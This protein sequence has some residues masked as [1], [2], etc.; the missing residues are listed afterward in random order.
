MK[1]V[2]TSV[3][4]DET[5]ALLR[6]QTASV[7]ALLNSVLGKWEFGDGIDQLSLVIV[8]VDDDPKE[9]GKWVAPHNKLGSLSHP[10][11]GERIRFLSLAAPIPPSKLLSSTPS[12]GTA[13][14]REALLVTLASRPERLPR[15]YK[16]QDLA[17]A[18]VSVLSA[19]AEGVGP[20]AV[21]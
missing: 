3:A 20:G 5:A 16:F 7:D 21:A 8:S 10:I 18:V 15:G 13:L 17:T 6:D 2:V 12:A 1:F 9:N 11:S 19:T 4:S 14:V